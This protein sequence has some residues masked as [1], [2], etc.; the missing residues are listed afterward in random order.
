MVNISVA[1][2]NWSEANEKV[3]TMVEMAR[4][5]AGVDSMFYVKYLIGQAWGNPDIRIVS[6]K[7]CNADT[8]AVR[9]ALKKVVEEGLW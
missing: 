7:S 6:F 9:V 1:G 2:L 3:H 8:C 5:R 4:K